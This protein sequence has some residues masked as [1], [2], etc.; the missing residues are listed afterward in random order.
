MF[1]INSHN[2]KDKKVAE[3]IANGFIIHT[4]EDGLNLLVD[5]YYQDFDKIILYEK[6]I[7][8]D[9]FDLKNGMAGEILQKFSNFRVRLVIVGD[10]S[11]YSGQAIKDFIF[12]S[13]K[14][15]QI[16]FLSTLPEALNLFSK[17]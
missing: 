15:K 11:K 2:I 8:P 13:N 6:N 7:V 12:E 3:V 4:A 10:F 16:N 14:L 9:F 1:T 5:L 17:D